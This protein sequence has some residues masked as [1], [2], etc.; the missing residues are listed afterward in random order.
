MN[1]LADEGVDRQIVDSLRQEGPNIEYIAE[2]EPSISDEVVFN[3]ANKMAALLLTADKDFGEIVFRD[4]RLSSGGVVLIRLAG[5]PS[6][7]KAEKWP[8]LPGYFSV[9][10]AWTVRTRSKSKV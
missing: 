7:T 5:L 2:V 6:E 8:N 1:I 9:I 4:G 10:T 3:R